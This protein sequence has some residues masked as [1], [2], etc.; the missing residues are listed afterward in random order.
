MAEEKKKIEGNNIKTSE[1]II[2]LLAGLFILA[3]VANALLNFLGTLE[4]GSPQSIWDAAAEYFLAEIWPTWKLI[5]VSVSTLLIV[6]IIYN[7]KKTHDINVEERKIYNPDPASPAAMEHAVSKPRNEK[8]EKVMAYANSTNSSDW[9]LAIIEADVI[10]EELMRTLG[11]RG[12]SLGEMLKSVDKSD[13]L[14][15]ED[16]WEAH[17][18][19]N[20]IAHSGGTFQLS[21]RETRRVIAL[22]E[23]VF[24]EFQVI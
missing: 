23:K 20:S 16:A 1:Q 22:F 6:G 10:L 19:R 24:K 11:Y 15:I 12:E 8:W 5:A 9:K 18:V 7:L 4:A 2:V 17:K 14:T 3:A 13:F 21:D